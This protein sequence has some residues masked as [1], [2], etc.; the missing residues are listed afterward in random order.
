MC[1]NLTMPSV[2]TSAEELGIRIREARLGMKR[3]Q[4]QVAV[5]LGID[6]T[7]V[8]RLEQGERGL[9]T[10]ELI[11]LAE[12]LDLPISYFVE[13]PTETVTSLRGAISDDPDVSERA[14]FRADTILDSRLRSAEFLLEAGTLERATRT[15][16][17]HTIRTRED[18]AR[19]AKEAREAL[20]I[21]GP[22]PEI[23]DACAAFGLYVFVERIGIDGASRSPDP[24]FGVA[25]VRDADDPGRRRA[26][27]A[28]E[29]GHHLLGDAYTADF[30]AA[31]AGRTDHEQLVDVFAAQFLLPADDLRERL[32]HTG[33]ETWDELV[34]TAAHH[35]V[36]WSLAIRVAADAR[37][38][39]E[40]TRRR[41]STRTPL[42]A[43][44]LRIT[45]HDV[46]EDLTFQS[47]GSGWTR[48]VMRAH[49]EDLITQSRAEEL[50]KGTNPF[51]SATA[52]HRQ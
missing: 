13:R 11:T 44:M 52:N 48:A 51:G 1:D 16:P 10:L 50:L 46:A 27:A 12:F 45:G 21:T 23:Q 24:D 17:E 35:R 3:S 14:R 31:G 29:L 18:A 19:L 47:Y 25:I 26:T 38:I 15:I 22:V 30:G 28:H 2:I 39:D 6:R 20:G 32:R 37:I 9:S 4:S 41:F 49:A 34:A 8:T 7:S 36:S 33:S 42:R 40:T 43:D 5:A